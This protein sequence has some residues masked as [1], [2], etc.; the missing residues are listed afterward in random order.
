MGQQFL[1]RPQRFGRPVRIPRNNP[2]TEYNGLRI[3]SMIILMMVMTMKTTMMIRR[4]SKRKR[5]K[6]KNESEQLAGNLKVSR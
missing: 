1:R 2:G 5:R 4:W 6:S 3:A